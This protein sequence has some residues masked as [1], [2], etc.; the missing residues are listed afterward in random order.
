MQDNK[1]IIYQ[2][3]TRLFGNNT[4]HCRQNGSKAENG[5]GQMADFTPKALQE[6]KQLGATH[7][8][9]TGIIEHA[10]QTDYSDYGISLDH[11]AVVKGK[12]GSPYA[13]KDY[14]DVD[15]DLATSVPDRMKEFDKLVKRTHRAGLKMIID[16]VPNHVARQYKSDN[17]PKGVR[18][19]GADDDTHLAFS[20]QNNFYYIPD[21][22]LQGNIDLQLGA[23]KP[24]VEFPAKA[25]GNDRFN[26][27][28]NSNDWYETVKLNYGIDYVGGGSWHF[29][30]IP[31]TWKKMR[32]ILLFWA[33]KGI[34]GF[35]CDMA[36]MVPCAFW[37]WA[38]PQVKE[39]YPDLI[40]IAEVYNPGEYRNYLF[41]G[42]FDYLYD[43][44]GLYDTLRAVTCGNESATA[45]TR[46]WQNLEGISRHMLNFLENHDEQRLASQYFAGNGERGKPALI[47]SA[48]L[49]TSPFMLYFGQELGEPGMDSE[50]F[51][52]IDGRTTIF[53]YWT[54]DSIRRWRNGGKFNGRLMTA[55]EK[56]LRAF[57]S[58]LLNLCTTEKALSTGEF[59]DLMYV[60]HSNLN[61]NEHRHYA[62]MR[63]ADD[64]LLVIVANFDGQKANLHVQI[65]QHA[66]DHWNIP[67]SESCTAVD[68]LTGNE[69]TVTLSP[70]AP[71]RTQVEGCNGKILKIKLK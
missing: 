28:P 27:W 51:S 64:E 19:L 62:F 69:E 50:G 57:Y 45:I 24:Y 14:Y 4:V 15:P 54:V 63:K 1:F 46:C 26:A 35:R 56:N 12:A 68:L 25:T 7:I 38:I 40:F 21:T 70:T 33:A 32:D 58:K 3:F 30:P 6:I 61:F 13:I 9:Y 34:D 23:D 67:V 42:K 37:G 41:N 31:D 29:S 43:K 66:F 11:P 52:G 55:E 39:Q 17:C 16:F 71:L 36:E 59:F 65:P 44:V 10:T 48:C 18:D 5:C 8:W 47:V 20:P 60:N 2:V 22:P 49:N 53:D